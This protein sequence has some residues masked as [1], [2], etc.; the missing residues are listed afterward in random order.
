MDY[1][2]LLLAACHS[3]PRDGIQLKTWISHR[4]TLYSIFARGHEIKVIRIPH[5]KTLT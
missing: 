5:L 4:D 2:P 1:I 3:G